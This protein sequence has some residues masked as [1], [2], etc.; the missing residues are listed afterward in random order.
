M[1]N[2]FT[3]LAWSVRPEILKDLLEQHQRQ[4]N[5]NHTE[6]SLTV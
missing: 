1:V 3:A 6:R 4:K 2:E 5:I